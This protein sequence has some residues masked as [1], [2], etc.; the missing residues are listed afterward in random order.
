MSIFE[1]QTADD[2]LGGPEFEQQRRHLQAVIVDR[3]AGH[4]LLI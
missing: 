3:L 1:D 4:L 2:L